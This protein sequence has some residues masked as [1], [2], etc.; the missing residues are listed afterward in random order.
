MQEI[1]DFPIVK[2]FN[3]ILATSLSESGRPK[4][5]KN[6]IAIPVSSD[7]T[8]GKNDELGFDPFDMDTTAKN[9]PEIP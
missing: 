4:G 8:K 3:S 2:A 1:L 9:S 7:H 5:D 6:R